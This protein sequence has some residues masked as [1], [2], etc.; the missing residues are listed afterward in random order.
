LISRFRFSDLLR[1]RA[2]VPVPVVA[3]PEPPPAI[4]TSFHISR[5]WCDQANVF[6]RG[7]AH[8]Y[9][10]PVTGLAIEIGAVRVPVER[11]LPSEQ[12]LE[13]FPEFPHLARTGFAVHV[14]SAPE[15]PMRLVIETAAGRSVHEFP[16]DS[17]M[18]A[19]SSVFKYAPK[20]VLD[21]FGIFLGVAAQLRGPVLELIGETVHPE[22]ER[23]LAML[24][25]RQEHSEYRL[26]TPV[27]TETP[28]VASLATALGEDRYSGIFSFGVLDRVPEP[29]RLIADMQS[30]LTFHGVIFHLVGGPEGGGAHWEITRDGLGRVFGPTTL[31]DTVA[32]GDHAAGSEHWILARKR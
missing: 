15:P 13:Y 30:A 26:G 7:W 4:R 5:L 24:P 10:L 20:E 6:V 27:M 1:S 25:D 11:F 22:R 18:A 12:L 31:F 2:P 8:A 9:D 19:R 17:S 28:D 3:A 23:F 32:M 14:P 29:W 16:T 21:G